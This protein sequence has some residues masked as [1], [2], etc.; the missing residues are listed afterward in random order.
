MEKSIECIKKRIRGEHEKRDPQIQPHQPSII[1]H[2]CM[3]SLSKTIG[4]SHIYMLSKIRTQ[5][6]AGGGSRFVWTAGSNDVA[7][8]TASDLTRLRAVAAA[9]A[10]HVVVGGG[11]AGFTH[12]RRRRWR[13]RRPRV[14]STAA[15]ALASLVVVG[16]GDDLV[17]CRQRRLHWHQRRLVWCRCDTGQQQHPVACLKRIRNVTVERCYAWSSGDRFWSLDSG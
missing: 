13:R 1:S 3:L 14:V 5:D 7:E 11:C 10:S 6:P 8:K 15:A 12:C 4:I 2:I 17:W 9:P 16:G